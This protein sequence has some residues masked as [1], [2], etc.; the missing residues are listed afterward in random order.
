M[1][2]QEI[3]ICFLHLNR[4]ASKG[5]LMKLKSLQLAGVNLN[6]EDICGRSA[7][8]CTTEACQKSI[9][10]WLLLQSNVNSSPR[11]LYGVTPLEAAKLLNHPDIFNVLKGIESPP[12]PTL[13]L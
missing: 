2:T 13:N 12:S 11:N 5:D 7:I 6:Q 4:A 3:D 10:E 8:L 9:V 1:V